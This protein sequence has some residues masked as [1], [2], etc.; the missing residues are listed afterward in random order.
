MGVR[1]QESPDFS[2]PLDGVE[3][4]D[5]SPPT[6]SRSL[7]PRLVVPAV[8]VVVLV[9]LGEI[10]CLG[11]LRWFEACEIVFISEEKF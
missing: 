7:P 5:H 2:L 10:L 4:L 3:V 11:D 9:V 6:T 8:P 1:G